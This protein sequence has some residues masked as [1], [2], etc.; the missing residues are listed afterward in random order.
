MPTIRKRG[1]RW[2]AQVRI[3][4]NGEIV[5]QES[6]TFGTKKQADTWA[7]AL[8]AKVESVGHTEYTQ[9]S[10]AVRDIL[11]AWEKSYF[12]VK[13][14]SR[15]YQHSLKALHT[16]PFASTAL[17]S[18][19][20]KQ[21]VDWAKTLTVAPATVLH[22]LMVLR[23]AMTQ[24][25][26][27]INVEPRMQPL[28]EALDHLKRLRLTAKS[29]RRDRRVSD[30]ELD[31]IV[32]DLTAM[33]LMVPTNTYVRLAVAL[34][35][36]REEICEMLWSD[37]DGTTLKLRDT[38]SPNG[39][40][41]EVIPVPPAAKAIIDTLDKFDARIFPYKPESVSAAFQRCVRRIG[42]ED[43]RLHDLRHEGISRLF[44]QGLSIPEVAL[45]SGHL[46]WN[47]LRRYTHLKPQDV[48]EKLNARI[49]T[50]QKATA[51]PQES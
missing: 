24:T 32:A 2:N 3:R 10:T 11:L 43:I 15:G 21:I 40:R 34:P 36:R 25:R 37:Y 31:A 14:M 47:T 5:F 6:A 44:E 48:V 35:R 38:K 42:L 46:S 28:D 18:L 39:E 29:Q 50:A 4:R 49:Q 23:S 20:A 8:E 27:L 16:A 13:T 26:V 41:T 30:T 7:R 22:H 19:S 12:K 51:Q 9:G 33:S 45:I 1:D 17:K